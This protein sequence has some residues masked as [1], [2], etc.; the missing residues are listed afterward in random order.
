MAVEQKLKKIIKKKG[1]KSD[2]SECPNWT[3]LGHYFYRP[4]F[5]PGFSASPMQPVTHPGRSKRGRAT[6]F[7]ISN[8]A[9]FLSFVYDL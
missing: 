4:V 9:L 6:R 2:W 1:K 5:H 8:Y 3:G 7:H